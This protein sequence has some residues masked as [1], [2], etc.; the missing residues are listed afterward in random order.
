M[1][2]VGRS[3][4]EATMTELSL[5][6]VKD[7]LETKDLPGSENELKVLCVRI[8]NLAD[9]NGE[10]WVRQNCKKLL[11]EWDYIVRRGIIT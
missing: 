7:L 11:D 10:G 5:E 4:F 2:D 6:K 1:F 8:R 3:S 9:M